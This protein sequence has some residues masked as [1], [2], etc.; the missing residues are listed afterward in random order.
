MR[1]LIWAYD[2]AQ[3]LDSLMIPDGRALF[4]EEGA[5]VF[6]AGRQCRTLKPKLHASRG[7]RSCGGV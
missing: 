3:S 2:E 4:G 5:R 1:C 7:M 6:G